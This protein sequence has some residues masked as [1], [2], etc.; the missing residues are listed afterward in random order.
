VCVSFSKFFI[1]SHHI[2]HVF[3]FSCHNPGPKVYISHFSCF[4][5]FF[6][7][8]Q[9][10]LWEFLIFLFGQFFAIFQVPRCAFL[11]FTFFSVSRHIPGPTMCVSHF[12]RFSVFLDIFF[13]LKCVFLIF[14]DFQVSYH[15][16]DPSVGI[17][18]FSVFLAIFQV[19]QCL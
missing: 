13:V 7:I 3:Q 10:L 8:L 9:V 18:H 19:I 15:I 1:V 14:H 11:F 4:S 12:A 17:S 5:V 6:T 16:P 2:F